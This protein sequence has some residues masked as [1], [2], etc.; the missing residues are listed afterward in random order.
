MAIQV[1]GIMHAKQILGQPK[2]F[3]RQATSTSVDVP[4][5][6]WAIYVG[7]RAKRKDSSFQYYS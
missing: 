7:E 2:L 3:A 5:G 4:K 6:Y 1:T